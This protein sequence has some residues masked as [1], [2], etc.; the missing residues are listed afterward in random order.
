MIKKSWLN[1]FDS[2]K[3]QKILIEFIWLPEM[4]KNPDWIYVTAGIDKKILI[5]FIWQ[6]EMTKS[7]DWIYLT[8]GNDKQSFL[9][10]SFGR[11]T[12]KWPCVPRKKSSTAQAAEL[13]WNGL[14]VTTSQEKYF[15]FF[16]ARGPD[17]RA[18]AAPQRLREPTKDGK[19][20]SYG[21][22]TCRQYKWY[23]LCVSVS[24]SSSVL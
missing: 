7:P 3:W 12:K 21:G 13:L 2:R 1:L 10:S 16:L 24:R 20:G 19:R 8:A 9:S 6:P 15:C 11:R 22:P 18:A 17:T 14:A 23:C 5:E 4:T